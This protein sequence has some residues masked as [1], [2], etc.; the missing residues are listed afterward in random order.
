MLKTIIFDMGGTLEDIVITPESYLLC[1]EKMLSHLD[2]HG[3]KL[4]YNAREFME[5]V[6][7]NSETYRT[8][9]L[10]EF[11]ELMPYEQW[12]QWRM[13]D[14]DIGE[15][16]LRAISEDLMF[17]WETAYFERKIRPD[18]ADTLK[19]LKG[20]GYRLGVIS[21][22][23]S[24]T[25]V[26]HTLEQHG[27]RGYFDAVCLSVIAGF[28]KPHPILFEMTA[29]NLDS[30]PEEC[31]YVG[32]TL[33][34]DVLGARRAGFGKTFRIDSFLTALSD[35]QFR[36]SEEDKEDADH[37]IGNLTELIGLLQV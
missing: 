30:R 28:R 27:I 11:V 36:V 20:M 3:I 17:I 22:T 29:R 37:V 26:Y 4:P 5:I 2:R 14:F 25:Q 16:I 34:R 21:N 6:E 12:S 35:A 24:L 18:A 7:P 9:S 1:G 8:W 15:D 31:A 10:Q 19:A 23:S 13:K 32:D 33:T